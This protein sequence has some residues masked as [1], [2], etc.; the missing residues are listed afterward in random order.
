MELLGTL[1]GK[2]RGSHTADKLDKAVGFETLLFSYVGLGDEENGKQR[3]LTPEE[4]SR[5]RSLKQAALASLRR[6]SMHDTNQR[7]HPPNGVARKTGTDDHSGKALQS[8]QPHGDGARR[9]QTSDPGNTVHLKGVTGKHTNS[10]PDATPAPVL[11]ASPSPFASLLVQAGEEPQ[12]KEKLQETFSTFGRVV[13]IQLPTHRNGD[14]KVRTHTHTHTPSAHTQN[15][16]QARV[17]SIVIVL[18]QNPFAHL[19]YLQRGDS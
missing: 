7:K 19:L 17:P 1:L 14:M 13:K 3:V 2:C 12:L 8:A 5:Y 15:T 9:E 10:I 6:P 11:R 18:A 16:E 4:T